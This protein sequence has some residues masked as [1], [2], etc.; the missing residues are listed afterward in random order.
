M[1]DLL[2]L[3]WEFICMEW[4]T[5]LVKVLYRSRTLQRRTLYTF[6]M[7]VCPSVPRC[8]GSCKSL[9]SLLP[10]QMLIHLLQQLRRRHHLPSSP[11]SLPTPRRIRVVCRLERPRVRPHP[12]LRPR[13]Q[14][15][16]PRRTRPSVLSP[17]TDTCDVPVE[18]ASEEY[19]EVFVEDGGGGG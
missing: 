19:Q 9:L 4:R 7:S 18:G 14:S 16:L 10:S 17:Y 3:R 6:V 1:D 11:R 12:P 15:T 2:L 13:N 8:S 5:P